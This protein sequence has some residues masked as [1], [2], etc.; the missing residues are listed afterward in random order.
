MGQ[1]SLAQDP[2]YHREM[3]RNLALLQQRGAL[4]HGAP[5]DKKAASEALNWQTIRLQ[6]VELRW[7]ARQVEDAPPQLT[8]ICHQSRRFL[9]KSRSVVAQAKHAN[10][11]LL[12]RIASTR[13]VIAESRKRPQSLE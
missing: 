12:A 3:H 6:V 2:D 7:Q 11:K 13:E 8:A 10:E 5:D 1:D 9:A 4:V